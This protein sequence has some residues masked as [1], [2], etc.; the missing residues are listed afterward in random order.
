MVVAKIE[1][2][3]NNHINNKR[4]EPLTIEKG[5]PVNSLLS[6]QMRETEE[7]NNYPHLAK[8]RTTRLELQELKEKCE[9]NNNGFKEALKENYQS[10][11]GAKSLPGFDAMII[12][13]Q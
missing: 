6:R 8:L 5:E 13:Y 12:N 11:L 10:R 1:T 7:N 9:G 4:S 2:E 3:W